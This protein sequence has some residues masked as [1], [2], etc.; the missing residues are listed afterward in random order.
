MPILDTLRP[1]FRTLEAK[2]LLLDRSWWWIDSLCIDLDNTRER[3]L[4]VQLMRHLY[5]KCHKCIVWMGEGSAKSNQAIDFIQLLHS[6]SEEGYDVKKIRSNLQQEEYRDSWIS[7]EAFFMQRWWTRVWTQQEFVLPLE[8][9]FWCGSRAISRVAVC[10]SLLIADKYD[11]TGFDKSLAFRQGWNRRRVWLIHKKQS[12]TPELKARLSI[13]ALAAYC[14][15]NEAIN[16]LDRLYGLHGLAN[17]D[18]DLLEIDYSK[19]V[20]EIYF[21]YTKSFIEKHKSLDLMVFASIFL[22]SADSSLPSWVP[23]WRRTPPSGLLVLP[24]MVSQSGNNELGNLRPPSTLYSS[25]HTICYSAAG[26]KSA[27]YKFQGSALSVSGI[28]LD[29]LNIPG[30]GREKQGRGLGND[31]GLLDAQLTMSTED[32]LISVC[33]SLVLARRDRYLRFAMPTK[34]FLEDFLAL[35]ALS[36]SGATTVESSFLEWFALMRHCEFHRRNLETL[37]SLHLKE[38]RTDIPISAPNQDHHIQ[39]SFFG[40]FYDTIVR[41]SLNLTFTQNGRVGMVPP[42]ARHGDVVCILY[43]CSVPVLLRKTQGENTYRLVGECFID[44]CMS[45]EALSSDHQ[46]ATFCIK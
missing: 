9:A 10:A 3:S 41:M 21:R 23:D 12:E 32:I 30:D 20:D 2:G 18:R 35:C 45:G 40:R 15:T 19:S 37:I 31:S 42:S 14:C 39:D 25:T 13:P 33:R 4:Q 44:Q 34:D 29:Y 36:I 27:T 17:T 46:E 22:P 7:L 26:N 11:P 43:G 1:F 6:L 38:T 5:S 8:V 16:D 24:L 28:A